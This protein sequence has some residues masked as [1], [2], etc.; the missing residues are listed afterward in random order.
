MILRMPGS[1]LPPLFKAH[2][3]ILQASALPPVSPD[4]YN[5]PKDQDK[6]EHILDYCSSKVV[7]LIEALPSYKDKEWTRL[8][9]DILCYYDVE[10]RE[11]RYK[12]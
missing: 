6:C 10:L 1:L 8:E 3:W 4:T 9:R 11:T 7:K 2:V 5:V 12:V